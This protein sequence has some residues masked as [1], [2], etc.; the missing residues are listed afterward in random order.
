MISVT[1]SAFKSSSLVIFPTK[2]TMPM[3]IRTKMIYLILIFFL[4]ILPPLR[5]A[6]HFALFSYLNYISIA[7]FFNILPYIFIICNI[8][9]IF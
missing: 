7:V 2:T 9:F 6:V 1:F 5:G 3:M 8:L 4:L